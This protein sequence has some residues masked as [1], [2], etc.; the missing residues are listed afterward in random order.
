[1]TEAGCFAC[2]L[3]AGTARL[4]GGR[5]Y[6]SSRWVVEHTVGPLGLGTLVVKPFRHVVHLAD[7][8]D[9]ESA[10][11]GPLLRQTAAAVTQL[12]EPEQVYTCLWSHRGAV[13]VHIHFVVQP[14]TRSDMTRFD[15][16]GPDLQ[17]AMFQADVCPDEEEIERICERFRGVFGPHD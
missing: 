9:A 4:P 6:Q 14:I 3:I 5:L 8:D 12:V 16:L 1:M 17:V 11:L 2:D 10:E 15:A 13:P 7:L